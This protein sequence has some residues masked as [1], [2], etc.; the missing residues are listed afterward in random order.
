M[1]CIKQFAAYRLPLLLQVLGLF[2]V[3]A[4]ATGCLYFMDSNAVASRAGQD[5]AG[6]MLL[7]LNAC[8]VL[9]VSALMAKASAAD[10]RKQAGWVMSRVRSTPRQTSA[11]WHRISSNISRSTRSTRSADSAPPSR[12]SRHGLRLSPLSSFRDRTDSGP[13]S[14]VDVQIVHQPTT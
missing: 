10:I 3:L 12:N 6:V 9:W 1:A 7:L 4:T 5:V 8:L 14:T 2:T 13:I 11:M